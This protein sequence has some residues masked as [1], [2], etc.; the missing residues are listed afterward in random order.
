VSDDMRDMLQAL[1]EAQVRFLVVGAFAMAVHG[2]PRATGDIDIWIRPDPQNAARVMA[3]LR[4]FGAPVEQHGVV[5]A[6]FAAEGVVYEMG[7]PPNR[8]DLLTRIDGVTFDDAFARRIVGALLG[9]AVPVI[10]LS[11]LIANKRASGRP[12]DLVDLDVLQSRA[13]LDT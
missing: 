7:V 4:A 12:K 6:D 2:L 5:A 1:T 9:V 8:I 13:S 10:G 11:D 3:A